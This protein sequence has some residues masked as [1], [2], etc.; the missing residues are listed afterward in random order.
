MKR[1]LPVRKTKPAEPKKRIEAEP[2]L[3]F[4]EAL[5]PMSVQ[6][7]QDPTA[8]DEISVRLCS[9]WPAPSFQAI[10]KFRD[11]AA[12][13]ATFVS[14]D[15]VSALEASISIALRGAKVIEEESRA[16][17]YQNQTKAKDT[18]EELMEENPGLILQG[19]VELEPRQGWV[20]VVFVT[21]GL[22]AS[23]LMHLSGQCE[24]REIEDVNAPPRGRLDSPGGRSGAKSKEP[25]GAPRRKATKGNPGAA[26]TPASTAPSKPRSAAPQEEGDM[27]T[28]KKSALIKYHQE[29]F[30][31]QPNNKLSVDEIVDLIETK[32]AQ[33]EA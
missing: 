10:T 31:K 15:P 29:Q 1:P 4:Y 26:S 18:L 30:G 13:W 14:H 7:F 33:K 21:P 12:P 2:L 3:D 23:E 22:P 6:G 17:F 32:L 9:L 25:T 5:Y 16:M 8:I 11:R 19:K 27:R 20:P 24:I 28:W